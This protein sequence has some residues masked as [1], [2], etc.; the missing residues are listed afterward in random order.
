MLMILCCY[1]YSVVTLCR[2]GGRMVKLQVRYK[3]L[4]NYDN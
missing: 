3:L 4:L 1:S 2:R